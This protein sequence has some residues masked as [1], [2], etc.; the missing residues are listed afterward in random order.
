MR[1]APINYEPFQIGEEIGYKISLKCPEANSSLENYL[2]NLGRVSHTA[3]SGI[4]RGITHKRNLEELC[5]CYEEAVEFVILE[6][7][8][9]WLEELKQVQAASSGYSETTEIIHQ[10]TWLE[11]FSQVTLES[12]KIENDL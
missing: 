5:S 7:I 4:W 9:E 11:L 1:L 10:R 6:G 3:Q 2:F 8:P 12:V